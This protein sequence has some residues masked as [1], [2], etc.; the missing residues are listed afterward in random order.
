V[1]EDLKEKRLDDVLK[2]KRMKAY[3]RLCH[4]LGLRD[5][6]QKRAILE[7]VLGLDTHP[8]AD[9]IH[10]HITTTHP[11]V[12]RTTVYRGL[13]AF[14]RMG[15]ITKACHPGSVTRYD[16]N[17]DIHHHLICLHCDA[18]IDITDTGLDA[19]SIPDTSDFNFEVQDFRVQLRGVC[20]SCRETDPKEE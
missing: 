15:L 14:A 16:R 12:S 17:I 2:T 10:A 1:A 9:E 8:T 5:T 11:D 4:E 13:E 7:A 19:L 20:G 3:R 18:V 6:K